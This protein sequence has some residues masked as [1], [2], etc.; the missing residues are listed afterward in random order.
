MYHTAVRMLG[1]RTDAEDVM[2]EVFVRVFDQLGAFRGESTLGAWIKRITVNTTLNH[3]RR[4]KQM[5]WQEL[6]QTSEIAVPPEQPVSGPEVDVQRIHRAIKT[7]PEGCRVIFNLHA[8]E[9]YQHQEIAQ[10]LDI[11]TSTSKSQYRRARLMLQQKLSN[12][13]KVNDI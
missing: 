6:P 7:L 1:N 12:E 11:S 4:K 10:I 3:L 9:G 13:F 8:L 5:H 2:Q